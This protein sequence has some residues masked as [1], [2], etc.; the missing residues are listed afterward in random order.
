MQLIAACFIALASGI[1]PFHDDEPAFAQDATTANPSALPAGPTARF[2]DADNTIALAY[3][4]GALKADVIVNLVAPQQLMAV[5]NYADR[6]SLAVLQREIADRQDAVIKTL[7]AGEFDLKFRYENIC[8][9]AG[10]ITQKSLAQLLADARVESIEAD[11][12]EEAHI[13]QGAVLMNAIATRTTYNG[14]G[15]SVAI[16][17][18][19]IDYMHPMLGGAAFPNAKV[20][21]GRDF[22]DND[23]DP[24]DCQGHGTKCAG[25]AAGSLGIIGNYIGGMAYNAKIYAL[26][27][28]SACNSSAPSSNITAAWDWCVTHKNDDPNNPIMVISTSFGGGRYYEPCDSANP[29]RT[30]AANAA[31]AAG[32]TLFCSSGNSG[33]CDSMGAPACISSVISVGAVYDANLGQISH[34]VTADSCAPKT[35]STSC[36]TGWIVNVPS[37]QAGA[38]IAYSNTVD[39]LGVL[40]PS[41]NATTTSLN[42]AYTN[43]FNGTSAACP[44]AAG[45]AACLQQA[46][47]AERGAYLTPAQVRTTL[48]T[49]GTPTL[50]SKVPITKSRVNLGNAVASLC[51]CLGDLNRDGV[52]NGDD[53]QQFTRCMLIGGA[54]A[55]ANMDQAGGVTTADMTM[56]ID[57]LLSGAPCP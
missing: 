48:Q 28:V 44:Y 43:S 47:L 45:A 37:A 49:T 27:I 16:V 11:V 25:L 17:D 4:A 21:G 39:F 20:I 51:D 56:F 3:Q 38:V 12:I 46:A 18:T 35:A 31:V 5:T 36:S 24:M 14:A 55:C 57:G 13:A 2:I 32:I 54:C 30:A 15:L 19:G 7:P 41:N 9:F 34:C 8:A 1:I 40:A 26:K 50:D 22:G 52:K 33:Y 6:A 53:V 23:D 29:S 10:A 42:G